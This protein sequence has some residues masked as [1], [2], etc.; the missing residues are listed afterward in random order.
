LLQTE[1]GFG[2]LSKAENGV[3]ISESFAYD[4]AK[5]R[6]CDACLSWSLC[7]RLPVLASQSSLNNQTLLLQ[8]TCRLE[9]SSTSQRTTLSSLPYQLWTFATPRPSRSFLRPMERFAAVGHNV[10]TVQLY[11]KVK[12]DSNTNTFQLMDTSDIKSI[13]LSFD[14]SYVLAFSNVRLCVFFVLMIMQNGTVYSV[15]LSPALNEVVTQCL[16]C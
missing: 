8:S 7:V 2:C 6:V 4:V 13:Q 10:L 16:M 1:Q 15:G 12:N 14:G 5:E 9:S 11:Q 3:W